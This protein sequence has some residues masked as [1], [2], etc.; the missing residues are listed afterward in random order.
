M[1]K[2]KEEARRCNKCGYQ[3]WSIKVEKPKTLNWRKEPT[4]HWNV[5][6]KR[7]AQASNRASQERTWERYALCSRCG[8]QQ[9][10]SANGRGFV[11]TALQE[12]RTNE[13]AATIPTS[14]PRNPPP[15]I[16]RNPPPGTQ[17]VVGARVR[18]HVLG[19]RGETGVITDVS[20]RGYLTV[21]TVSGKTVRSVSPD[22]ADVI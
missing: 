21:R 11:P 9:V 14:E 22:K 13:A 19:W 20:R 5:S 12:S 3:W 8:S 16:P 15:Q 10:S 6:A 18:L 4:L 17:L 2:D 1:S 7:A